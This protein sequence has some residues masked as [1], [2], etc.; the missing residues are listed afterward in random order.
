M[1]GVVRG[2]TEDILNISYFPKMKH[3]SANVAPPPPFLLVFQGSSV[4]AQQAGLLAV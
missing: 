4:L 1:V 2:E 3:V